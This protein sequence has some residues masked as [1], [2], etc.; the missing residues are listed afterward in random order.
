MSFM[1]RLCMPY[2]KELGLAR[3][4]VKLRPLLCNCGQFV[5]RQYSSWFMADLLVQCPKQVIYWTWWE[6]SPYSQLFW[7]GSSAEHL[8]L[9]TSQL[10]S[11]WLRRDCTSWCTP[12]DIWSAMCR[13]TW[14][15]CALLALSDSSHFLSFFIDF[16]I[17]FYISVCIF[18]SWQILFVI[19]SKRG[20]KA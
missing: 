1:K 7:D 3:S 19:S 14:C 5:E 2:P 16:C 4:L 10:R 18:D 12:P 15:S 11:R 8:F 6:S 13:S 17:V 20:S 9:C